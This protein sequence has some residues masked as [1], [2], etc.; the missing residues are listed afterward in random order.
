[1][2]EMGLELPSYYGDDFTY[3]EMVLEIIKKYFGR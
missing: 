2:R 1:M 3:S